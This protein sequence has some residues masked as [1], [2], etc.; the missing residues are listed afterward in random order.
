M[1]EGGGTLYDNIVHFW[2]FTE[3]ISLMRAIMEESILV[4]LAQCHKGSVDF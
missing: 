2:Q 4:M 1:L 3:V